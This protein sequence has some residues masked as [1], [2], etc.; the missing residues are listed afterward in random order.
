MTIG[1]RLRYK[2]T[3]QTMFGWW[4]GCYYSAF[5]RSP[6]AKSPVRRPRMPSALADAPVFGNC[7]FSGRTA[8]TLLCVLGSSFLGSSF[9]GSSFLGSSFLGSS[10]L[11]SS[12]GVSLGVSFSLGSSLGVSFGVS[13]SLGSSLGVSFGVSSLGSSFGFSLLLFGSPGSGVGISSASP[14]ARPLPPTR[15]MCARWYG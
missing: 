9:L 10:F 12:F 6:T 15:A 11:G 14:D 5:L 7:F 13:F 1:A 3:T 4:Y 2:I 8:C